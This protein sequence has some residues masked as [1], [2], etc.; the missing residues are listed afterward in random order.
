MKPFEA[1]FLSTDDPWFLSLK[2]QIFIYFEDDLKTIEK[3]DQ[4]YMKSQRNKK[5]L[6]NHKSIKGIKSIY[7][8]SKNRHIKFS[9]M[10]KV[11][12]VLAER[13]SQDPFEAY[14]CK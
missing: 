13:F 9:V 4:H 8:M 2:Y 14:F 1:S 3:E 5:C 6:L 11:S 7:I 12:Y 10:H